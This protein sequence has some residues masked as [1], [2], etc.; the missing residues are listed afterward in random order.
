MG[1]RN[2]LP[3]KINFLKWVSVSAILT[4]AGDFFRK[5]TSFLSCLAH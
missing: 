2:S 1:T 4:H 3:K 5:V